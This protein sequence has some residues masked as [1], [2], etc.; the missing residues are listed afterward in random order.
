[1]LQWVNGKLYLKNSIFFE[2]NSLGLASYRWDRMKFMRVE[3]ASKRIVCFCNA[4]FD[5]VYYFMCK[6]NFLFCFFL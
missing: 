2:G 6:K 1:M 4:L 5:I 3:S